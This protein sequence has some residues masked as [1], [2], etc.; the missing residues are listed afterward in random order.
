MG[1]GFNW[2]RPQHLRRGRATERITGD[3]APSIVNAPPRVRL[4]KAAMRAEADPL[5]EAFLARKRAQN[6]NSG[7]RQSVPDHDSK[8]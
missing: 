2:S 4:S 1:K 6:N 8:D 3:H 5:I 7:A